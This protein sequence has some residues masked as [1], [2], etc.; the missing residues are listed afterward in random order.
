MAH[1]HEPTPLQLER[2]IDRN[3]KGSMAVE[4]KKRL[5]LISE[6]FGERRAWWQ[7][8]A[9]TRWELLP[10]H[11]LL[12]LRDYVELVDFDGREFLRCFSVSEF[13]ENRFR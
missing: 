3:Y 5:E 7:A 13:W 4:I 8:A 10:E 1:V 11:S 2:Y 12:Q 9:L 6:T